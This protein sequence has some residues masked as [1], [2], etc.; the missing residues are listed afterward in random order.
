MNKILRFI[1][2][3]VLI[4]S[5]YNNLNSYN[6]TGKDIISNCNIRA[7]VYKGFNF[8]YNFQ[9]N[10]A[11]SLRLELKRNYNYSPWTYLYEANYYWW[12]I[13]SGENNDE[14]VECF[15][16]A[17]TTAR[18]KTGN[19]VTD[20]YQFLRIVIYSF[21]SRL[22]LMQSKYVNTLVELKKNLSVIKNTL[23]KETSFDGF[24][25][26]SGLYLYLTDVAYENY[27]YLRPFLLFVPSGNREKGLSYLNFKHN[28]IILSTES[29]Y[30]LMK[31]YDE[32]EK[33]HYKS[34]QYATELAKSYPMNYI[35]KEH[36][37]RMYCK[38][39]NRSL[40]SEEIAAF[41][42]EQLNNKQL[43]QKQT[44]YLLSIVQKLQSKS[45]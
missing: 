5:S 32:V 10:R 18:S 6:F 25:L 33:N 30:F 24:Y 1:L 17:L 26:T 31:I 43:S 34:L 35:F 23:G 12:K 2:V 42:K 36:Y 20:E 29:K 13:I 28:D 37:L 45:S 16:K 44:Q 38:K 9:F 14:N 41:K 27:V 22:D 19:I 21:M 39:N 7:E 40:T 4:V 3:F 8:L 11:D 15:Y